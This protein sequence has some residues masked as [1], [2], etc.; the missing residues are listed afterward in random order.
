MTDREKILEW[1]NLEKAKTDNRSTHAEQEFFTL[2]REYGMSKAFQ[3]TID[4][5][6]N[7]EQ[8]DDK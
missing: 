1:L 3:Q 6:T 7:M 4:F 5:I 2:T 8:D